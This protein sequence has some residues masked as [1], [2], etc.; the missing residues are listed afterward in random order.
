MYINL[1]EDSGNKHIAYVSC[2][3]TMTDTV[4]YIRDA[5]EEHFD[6]DVILPETLEKDLLSRNL[7][8]LLFTVNIGE[9]TYEI[10][11]TDGW[12]Y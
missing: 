8:M 2:R 6:E 11:A 12:V 1:T 10:A 3:P 7:D 4:D 5:L 9:C